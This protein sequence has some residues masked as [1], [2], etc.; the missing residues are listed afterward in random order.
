MSLILGVTWRRSRLAYVLLVA[1][2]VGTGA[3]G[4][5]DGKDPIPSFSAPGRAPELR[6]PDGLLH[7]SALQA[8]VDLQVWRD[9]PAL[10][11]RLGDPDPV[12]RARAA[13]ALGS[14]QWPGAQAAL[15]ELLDDPEASVRRDAAFAL[16]QLELADG[17]QALAL[18]L[19]REED[20]QAR[21]WM[22]E[23]IGRAGDESAVTSVLALE[24]GHEEMAQTRALTRAFLRGVRPDGALAA[25]VERLTHPDPE[26]R[27]AAALLF[28]QVSDT[29]VWA[30]HAEDVR[31]A[32][33]GFP[34]HE[35]A[36]MHLTLA[37]ARLGERDD[38]E[39]LLR[40]LEEGEDW[41]IRV[42]VARGLGAL[43]WLEREGVRT[44]LFGA[45]DDDSEHVAIA[46]AR[47]LTQGVWVPP[48]VLAQMEARIRGRSER[49]RVQAPFL[50]QVANFHDA[51]VVVDWTRRMV[52]VHPTA[53]G[54][55]LSALSGIPES[56][57]TEL[58]MDLA[59]HSD[60]EI[61]AAGVAALSRN[62]LFVVDAEG[63]DDR[64]YQIL[65][66]E[67]RD[68]SQRG[69]VHAAQS[70]IHPFFLEQG[71]LAELHA[72]FHGRV[73][74]G[75]LHVAG[76]LLDL[77]AHVGDPASLTLVEEA[78]RTGDAAIR[79]AA[80][81]ALEEHRGRVVP[82]K[83]LGLLEPERTVDWGFLASLGPAPRLILETEKGRIVLRL[84]PDQAPLTVQV[85]AEQA[86][87]GLHD[88]VPFHRV[89]PNFMVQG[90]DVAVGDGTGGPGYAIRSELNQLLFWRGVVGMASAGKDTE[91]SQ[92]FITHSTQLHLD[93]RMTPFGWVESGLETLDRIYEGDRVLR[94]TLE[95]GE[96]S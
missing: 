16:G 51:G 65:V 94:M 24:V 31:R 3:V 92:F 71:A 32:L 66:S 38:L 17:G 75:D 1:L 64:V 59:R 56:G 10:Q 28:G 61:R 46:A 27:E 82:L 57:I 40:W 55:G 83:E 5:C 35:P 8:V 84:V 78:T 41:R 87:P 63:R 88:G 67:I 86:M 48:H 62:W 54:W 2:S 15:V 33:D 47:A 39:R 69:A 14:V 34:A 74:Q 77:L 37:L 25:L 19:A 89:E 45:L 60:P 18:A 72:A 76:A 9:G 52:E 58:I 43:P 80:A 21:A 50:W 79:R 22:M 90:G 70:L 4:G 95:P 26:V 44:A 49:W 42:N 30:E 20:A 23:V 73:E 36:A 85:L 68:G 93:G 11:E 6:P 7:S 91:G 81:R 53:V 12:V 13:L 29:G 96:G